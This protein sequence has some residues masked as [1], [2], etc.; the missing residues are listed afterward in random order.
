M[1]ERRAPRVEDAGVAEEPQR[2]GPAGNVELEARLLPE[3]P[4][5]VGAHL[6]LDI[7]RA[8]ETERAPRRR[9]AAEVEVHGDLAAPAEVLR[10]GTV[11]ERGELREA[12]ARALRR[13][14]RQ[15]VA[16]L[17]RQRHAMNSARSRQEGRLNLESTI[18]VQPR[19]EPNLTYAPGTPERA[20]LRAT[21]AELRATTHELHSVIAG[22]R[23]ATADSFDVVEPHAHA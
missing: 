5:P 16:K 8:Q 4:S 14:L 9:G 1:L 23:I 17:L 3:R 6:A 15:L 7:E 13:D 21:V 18:A 20:E 19:N 12:V 11:E 2:L 10:P 22:E